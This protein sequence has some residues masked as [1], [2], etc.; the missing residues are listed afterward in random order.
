MNIIMKNICI[1][2]IEEVEKFLQGNQKV[3]FVIKKR[4]D[5]YEFIRKTL[6]RFKYKKTKRKNKGVILKYMIM[7]TGYSDIQIKR[8]VKEWKDGD[9]KSVV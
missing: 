5:K 6:V 3:L 8:L 9:R 7:V 1:E 4:K 2:S